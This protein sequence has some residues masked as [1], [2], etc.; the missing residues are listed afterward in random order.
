MRKPLYGLLLVPALAL[1]LGYEAVGRDIVVRDSRGLRQAAAKAEP[2]DAILLMPGEYRGGVSLRGVNG[3][4]RAPITIRGSDEK[5]PPVFTGGKVAMHLSDCNWIVLRN[6]IARG[7][8][9]NGINIDDGGT[10]E[11]PSRH[12]VL[13][14]LRLENTGPRG[15]HDALKLSGVDHFTVRDC[16][17]RGWG[18]SAID[19]VGCHDGVVEGCQFLGAEGFSQASGVQMK[20]GTSNITVRDSF[21]SNAGQRAINLGGST[22][23]QFFR[24]RVSNFEATDITVAG[25]RFVGSMAFVAW[26]TASG[27]H[28]HHN[29]FMFPQKWV[30]RIL[31]ETNDPKF[32]PCHDGVFENNLIVYDKRVRVFANVGPRTNPQSF[33][34]RQN[35]WYQVDGARRPVLPATER[36]GI[37]Q[38]DPKLEH[39]N[40][41][42]ACVSSRDPRLADIGADAYKPG[43]P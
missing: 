6:I 33:L 38:V 3:R 22:G 14:K 26:V 20:G 37:Y 35:A 27:G 10:F 5:R 39:A 21:F 41:R 30:L 42:Q 34:F 29:T 15:N 23:L 17:F 11:T 43:G 12:V 16:T 9:G 31:Q 2:G 32:K 18:G 7:F 40:T 13:E 36:N 1:S 25:N 4:K 28:V 24:P 8:P 19:M